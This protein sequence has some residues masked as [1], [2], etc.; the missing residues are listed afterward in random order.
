MVC[1][2]V[3]EKYSELDVTLSSHRFVCKV[4]V[5]HPPCSRVVW[6]C[7]NDTGL[8][9]GPER[10]RVCARSLFHVVCSLAA[11]SKAYDF[12]D[13]RKHSRDL[14]HEHVSLSL[15]PFSIRCVTFLFRDGPF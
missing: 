5:G 6:S 3:L 1:V 2:H 7:R 14:L 10:A 8:P 15:E 13:T 11:T 12:P 4:H 9:S